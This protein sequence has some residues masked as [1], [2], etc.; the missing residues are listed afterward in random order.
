MVQVPSYLRNFQEVVDA[1][2]YWPSF[3]DSP[4]LRFEV[5]ADSIE[6][7]IKAW[8]MTS[9]TEGRGHFKLTKEYE[10]GFRFS[11]LASTE[12][13]EF[14]VNNILFGLLFSP[15]EESRE[16]GHFSVELDS[17]MG[18]DLCGRFSAKEGEVLFVRPLLESPAGA[19]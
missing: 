12:L 18:C 17:A 8:E 3:H 15:D 1:F 7:E 9:E 14:I 16:R 11:G 2:G 6:L 13:D 4:V 10:I 5:A 19:K